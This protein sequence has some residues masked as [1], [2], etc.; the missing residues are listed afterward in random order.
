MLVLQDFA[1]ILEALLAVVVQVLDE[2]LFLHDLGHVLAQGQLRSGVL[3]QAIVALDDVLEEASA[4][5]VLNL[6]NHHVVENCAH[7]EES[8]SRLAEV[9]QSG[10]VKQYL[11]DYE[12][13]NG[14]A[15]LS[16]SLHDSKAQRYYL[17][18]KKEADDLRVVNFHEGT[19]DS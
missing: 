12:G 18:L 9:V 2:L 6:G 17:C 13:C 16:A 4:W 8:L 14:L 1:Q 15:Q 7:G 11:L 5:L 10:V 3:C 19:D